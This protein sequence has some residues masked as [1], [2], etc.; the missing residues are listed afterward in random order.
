MRTALA[1]S[2]RRACR[3]LAQPRSTQRHPARVPVDE[4]ALIARL[5][6]LARR[7]GRYTGETLGG[8]RFARPDSLEDR[9]A[10]RVAREVREMEEDARHLS[11]ADP[12]VRYQFPDPTRGELVTRWDMIAAPPDIL[13]SNFSMLNVMLM[14]ELEE[15]IWEQTRAWLAADP[16]N[17]FTLVVD[18]LHQQRGYSW[19]RGSSAVTESAAA[20]RCGVGFQ[21]AALHW[22]ERVAQ[23]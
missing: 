1:V 15:P 20:P 11:G 19:Q 18:E 4:P 6:A 14:R 12:E 16:S 10:Q 23:R 22:N 13:V 7:F 2:E 21:P 3:V 17:A 5:I 8:A 9:G